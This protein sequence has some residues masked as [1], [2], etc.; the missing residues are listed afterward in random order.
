MYRSLIGVESHSDM[1][2]E[3]VLETSIIHTPWACVSMKD[4]IWLNDIHWTALNSDCIAHS[5]LIELIQGSFQVHVGVKM[6]PNIL[7]KAL[8]V[9]PG[10][11]TKCTPAFR[12]SFKVNLTWTKTLWDDNMVSWRTRTGC[13]HF[14]VVTTWFDW[15]ALCFLF[16]FLSIRNIWGLQHS[17]PRNYNNQKHKKKRFKNKQ[18]KI[19]A[20][21]KLLKSNLFGVLV[22]SNP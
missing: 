17:V 1:I 12:V 6:D 3:L 10:T 20:R 4:E 9:S 18:C 8:G 16:L 11:I 7:A 14:E 15:E 2:L 5:H 13:C 19:Q 22:Y 21:F